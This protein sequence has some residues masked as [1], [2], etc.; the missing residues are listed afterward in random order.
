[1]DSLDIYLFSTCIFKKKGTD[2]K[3]YAPQYY[4]ICKG[5]NDERNRGR[6]DAPE[7]VAG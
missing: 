5:L 7:S 4:I 1:M 3:N 2:F 6:A